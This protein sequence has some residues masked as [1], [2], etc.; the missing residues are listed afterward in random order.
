MEDKG[1]APKPLI[2]TEEL[3]P[4]ERTCGTKA[5][6]RGEYSLGYPS[7][8]AYRDYPANAYSEGNNEIHLSFR[9]V[10]PY[11]V[12][13]KK[14]LAK[15]VVYPPQKVNFAGD[16]F[17]EAAVASGAEVEEYGWPRPTNTF[18][19]NPNPALVWVCIK[20]A[21]IKYD[22]TSVSSK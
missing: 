9:E 7:S 8:Y 16:P 6:V 13:L 1:D 19:D 5:D 15:M 2:T 3:D 10:A 21:S 18:I 4:N 17:Y 20:I 11:A 14:H 22:Q 12:P